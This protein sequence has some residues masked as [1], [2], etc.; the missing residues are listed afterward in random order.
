M[1][2][3]W[4]NLIAGLW[5]ILSAY[6]GFTTSEMIT[7]LTITGIIVAGLSLWGALEHNAMMSREDRMRPAMR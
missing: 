6:L 7:N 5:L 4:A 3:Q 1:W 2:Q